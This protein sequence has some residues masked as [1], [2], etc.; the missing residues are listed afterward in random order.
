MPERTTGPLQ[1]RDVSVGEHQG[2]MAVDL[3]HLDWRL[4]K[5]G[6]A[7][8]ACERAQVVSEGVD[9]RRLQPP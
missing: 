3:Q 2:T 9:E 5:F 1:V 4:N 6:H 8:S 7:G